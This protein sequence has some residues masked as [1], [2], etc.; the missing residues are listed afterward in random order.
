M[1]RGFTT[2]ADSPRNRGLI[3]AIALAACLATGQLHAAIALI[4]VPDE[5]FDSPGN[6]STSEPF[7]ATSQCT[8]GMRFQQIIDGDTIG[9]G[10][11]SGLGFRLDD[12]QP[13]LGSVTYGDTTIKLSSTTRNPGNMSKTFADNI[14]SDETLVFQGDFTVSAGTGSPT[15]P[16]DFQLPIDVPFE[17]DG[18]SHNLLID[19]TVENCPAGADGYVF[20]ADTRDVKSEYAFDKDA[21]TAAGTTSAGGLVTE[22]VLTSPP[23]IPPLYSCPFNGTGGDFLDRGF[24]VQDFPGE[25]LD[26][27]TLQ[28]Y[29]H[30]AG[31]YTLELTAREGGYDGRLIGRRTVTFDASGSSD[32][33]RQTYDFGGA[34][35]T[36]GAVVAFSHEIIR[37]P[38]SAGIS[39]DTASNS[40]GCPDIVQTHGTSPP[41]DSVRRDSVGLQITHVSRPRGLGGNWSVFGHSGEGF[42][43]DVT[44]S[45][46]LVAIWF[47]YDDAGNQMWLTGVAEDFDGNQATMS[48]NEVTGP[49]F[50]PDFDPGDVVIDDWGT[51]SFTFDN[52]EEG[53]VHYN[54]TTGFGSGV[55][56]I[57]KVYNTEQQMC[58]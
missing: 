19:V 48:V 30:A 23:P 37:R 49:V 41:L 15:N 40:G 55:Y 42:M 38:G 26:R 16:F 51:L 24:Y 6:S 28:Y 1:K 39:Y 21:G 56:E 11:I 9:G 52:C 46:Q 7:G 35:V 4:V 32:V 57:V 31:L 14:G 47:T 18:S 45:N 27:V 54:S 34:T 25:R 5:A 44:A 29:P 20:D 10:N 13:A 43:V 3:P 33:Q 2:Q 8:D 58:P 36:E 50:G 53:T 12:G 22:V 17:F